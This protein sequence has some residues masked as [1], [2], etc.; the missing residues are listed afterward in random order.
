VTSYLLEVFPAGADLKRTAP[1]ASS[2]L[3]KPAPNTNGEI[4]VDRSSFFGALPAG[5][6]VVTVAAVGGRG[7]S[8]SAPY[9]FTR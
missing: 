1:K 9:S 2:S 4:V 3:G 6:Y 7:K 5:S 8:R